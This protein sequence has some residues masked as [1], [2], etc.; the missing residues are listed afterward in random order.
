[1]FITFTVMYL[2][3]DMKNILSIVSLQPYDIAIPIFRFQYSSS[4]PSG[5]L[6]Y[7]VVRSDFRIKTMFR[8]CLPFT[9]TWVHFRLLGGVRAAHIL[10]SLLCFCFVCH[11]HVS[12]VS[13]VV[14][15]SRLFILDGPF[16]FL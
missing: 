5:V 13:I 12:C 11:R 6:I 16:G 8:N 10:F 2:G 4:P 14:D 1:M 7:P 3:Q 15:V 9:S